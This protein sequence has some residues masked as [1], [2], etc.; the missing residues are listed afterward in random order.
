MPH[1]G[2]PD[3]EAWV[4]PDFVRVFGTNENTVLACLSCASVT[5]V[6]RGAPSGH[7]TSLVTHNPRNYE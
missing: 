3:C 6:K 4:S 5:D 7:D 1:C 2:N